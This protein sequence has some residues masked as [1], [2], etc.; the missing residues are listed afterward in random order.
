MLYFTSDLHLGHANVIEFSHRPFEDVEQM[1]EA[2]IRNIN[3]RV[4]VGD[5]LYVLGDFAYRIKMDRQRELREQ[6]RCKHVHLVPGN[7]DRDWTAFEYGGVFIVEPPVFTL[8]R[9]DGHKLALCHY[10][11][12][13]WP[14]LRQ[15]A[16]H[17]HG[18]IHSG[19]EY[20]EW[21]REMR[22]LRYDVGVDANGYAPVSLEEVLAFFEGVE[23]RPRATR[24]TYEA[25]AYAPIPKETD[26]GWEP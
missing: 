5:E 13:D 26:R 10:P 22:L 9:E 23:H 25:L 17:L 19:P 11:M 8:K 24:D 3:D 21:N 14:G 18:H 20:N 16:I 4:R 2:L 1:N 15:G 7:H 6:I 12:M